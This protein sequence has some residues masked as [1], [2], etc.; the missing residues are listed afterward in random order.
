MFTLRIIYIIAILLIFTPQIT[1]A[2]TV[3]QAGANTLKTLIEEIFNEETKSFAPG[4]IPELRREGALS[5]EPLDGYYAITM[6][7]LQL[8]Y[9]G[10]AMLEIGIISINAR[11]HSDHES[12]WN[13]AAALPS[14]IVLYDVNEVPALKL[15]IAEQNIRG[16]WDNQNKRFAMIDAQLGIKDLRTVINGLRTLH[17]SLLETPSYQ[18]QAETIKTA[19]NW[20]EGFAAIGTRTVNNNGEDITRFSFKTNLAKTQADTNAN[21]TNRN[22]Q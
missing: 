7:H 9:P 15:E 20:L 10:E 13:V 4:N 21:K 3:D 2:S 5:I 17:K 22:V 18:A 19:I 16:V 1:L 8:V 12:L 14:P 11:P 6:P